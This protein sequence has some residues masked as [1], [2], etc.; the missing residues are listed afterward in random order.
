VQRPQIGFIKPRAFDQTLLTVP[1]RPCRDS[2]AL[3]RQNNSREVIS[4]NLAHTATYCRITSSK[5]MAERYHKRPFQTSTLV[6]PPFSALRPTNGEKE[7][8]AAAGRTCPQGSYP[9]DSLRL[10]LAQSQRMGQEAIPRIRE[11]DLYF[12]ARPSVGSVILAIFVSGGF[13]HPTV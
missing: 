11:G 13:L 3:K 1:R 7:D 9:T 5:T 4:T 2:S 10:A 8:A 12:A 6:L